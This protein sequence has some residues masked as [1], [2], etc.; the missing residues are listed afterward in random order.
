MLEKRWP[1]LIQD[2]AAK[3]EDGEEWLSNPVKIRA[4]LS[5]AD[6]SSRASQLPVQP[7]ESQM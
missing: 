7:V 1:G 4:T 6:S 5:N 2:C 3:D